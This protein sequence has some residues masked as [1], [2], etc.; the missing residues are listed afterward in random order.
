M[1]GRACA[2][3]SPRVI[4]KARPATA[5][6]ARRR[7]YALGVHARPHF[8]PACVRVR[9]IVFLIVFGTRSFSAVQ[10]GQLPPC[11]VDITLQK[12][13]ICGRENLAVDSSVCKI[14]DRT[15]LLSIFKKAKGF[16]N[17]YI[18]WVILSRDKSFCR[19]KVL[20]QTFKL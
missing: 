15:P 2:V 5:G 20:P 18:H 11:N 16:N 7:V 3:F 1:Q 4:K 14:M 19:G 6:R 8:R 17:V 13:H 9:E 12:P 10:S